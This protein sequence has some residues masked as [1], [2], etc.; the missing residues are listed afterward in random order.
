[1]GAM[2]SYVFQ[3]GT[4]FKNH[5][6][7]CCNFWVSL[8]KPLHL[9]RRKVVTWRSFVRS[10][11]LLSLCS[12]A[13]ACSFAHADTFQFSATGSGFSASGS[14]TAVAGQTA[15]AEDITAISGEVNGV[16]IAGLVPGSYDTANP[17]HQ[18]FFSVGAYN[19]GA[20][21]D[22]LLFMAG[23]GTGTLDEYGV[24]FTLADGTMANLYDEAGAAYYLD[25]HIYT[26]ADI[27]YPGMSVDSL[28]IAPAPEPSSLLL[29]GTGA[30]AA[31]G[32]MRRGAG[33]Q[34]V[35]AVS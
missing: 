9:S 23:D 13:F 7:L 25:N 24:E 22:D 28:A 17:S 3:N 34:R 5:S 31:F 1:M 8:K 2:M 29:L 26:A 33:R 20:I 16:A 10:R 4:C 21:F 35:R 30:L 27:N 14:I 19:Y 15:G 32:V 6:P 18:N 12:F 11:T